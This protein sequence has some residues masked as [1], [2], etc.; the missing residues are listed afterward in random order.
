MT[1]FMK[2]VCVMIFFLFLFHVATSDDRRECFGD[3]HCAHIKCKLSWIPRC[4]ST[5]QCKCMDPISGTTL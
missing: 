4:T 2:F 1:K 5:F 3:N